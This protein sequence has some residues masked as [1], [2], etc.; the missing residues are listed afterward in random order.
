MDPYKYRKCT[1]YRG[2]GATDAEIKEYE[3]LAAGIIIKTWEE[4][5]WVS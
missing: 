2:S 4:E 5:E 1:L 3:N